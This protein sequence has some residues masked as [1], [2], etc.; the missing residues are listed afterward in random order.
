MSNP[1]FATDLSVRIL[2]KLSLCCKP[3][4]FVGKP[5]L[6]CESQHFDLLGMSKMKLVW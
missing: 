1:R 4:H 3:Q 6:C 2:S 5:S